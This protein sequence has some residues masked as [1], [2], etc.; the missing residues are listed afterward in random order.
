MTR[1]KE[2]ANFLGEMCAKRRHRLKEGQ[3]SKTI[4]GTGTQL[5]RLRSIGWKSDQVQLLNI[6]SCW[7]VKNKFHTTFCA[8]GPS[9]S[10]ETMYKTLLAK[11]IRLP[12][13]VRLTRVNLF[14]LKISTISTNR[15]LM[16]FMYL[17]KKVTNLSSPVSLFTVA[18]AVSL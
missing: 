6:Y 9:C 13:A 1:H 14:R 8:I 10:A 7:C 2:C 4:S 16:K 3:K 5:L 12:R 11:F 18:W 15:Y 17:G